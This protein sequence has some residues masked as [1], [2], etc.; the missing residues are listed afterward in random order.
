[1]FADDTKTR[2]LCEGALD[3]PQSGFNRLYNMRNRNFSCADY[4]II[5]R[6]E[7]SMDPK[8]DDMVSKME[9]SRARLNAALDKVA[10]QAEIYP[11]WKMK[12]VM[13]HIA[14]W[15]ELVQS[16]LQAYKNGISPAPMI[17]DGIDPFNAASVAKRKA[18]P[19]EQS[20]RDYAA[21]RQRLIQELRKLPAEMLTQKYPAPWGGL[22]TI[23]SIVRIFVSHEQE[24]A[25]QI[26]EV[27]KSSNGEN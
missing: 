14:G 19:V 15:D 2:P 4:T 12:Q 6:G 21:A 17:V 7:K 13:D 10:P 9:R 22:C 16:T 23:S 8:I 26:E 11:A 24:H 18:L 1:M 3:T 20:R 5:D 25:Q 27:M